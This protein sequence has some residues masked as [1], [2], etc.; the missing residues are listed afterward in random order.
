MP[1]SVELSVLLVVFTAG[2][3]GWTLVTP[4]A[5]RHLKDMSLQYVEGSKRLDFLYI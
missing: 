1:Y 3:S 4:K 2:G 5:H